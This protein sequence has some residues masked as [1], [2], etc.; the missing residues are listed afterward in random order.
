[1]L[2]FIL[3]KKLNMSQIWREGKVIPV[4]LIEVSKNKVT[5]VRTKEKDGYEAVQLANGKKKREFKFAISPSAKKEDYAVGAEFDASAFKEGDVIRVTGVSKGR[6]FQGVVKRHGFGGGPKTH[7]QKNRL[8]APGSIGST[9]PQRVFPG[10]KMA[11]RMGNDKVTI[12]NLKIAGVDA[13][14]SILMIKGAVPGARGG[15]LQ[16]SKI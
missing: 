10:R 5:L 16:I 8:R 3:G 2:M 12:K 7:G 11:G 9:A 15:L 13:E 14:K 1:M 6:G 4:T